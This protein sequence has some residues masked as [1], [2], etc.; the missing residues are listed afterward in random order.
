MSVKIEKTIIE[1]FENFDKEELKKFFLKECNER[2][3]LSNILESV[4]NA[5]IVANNEGTITY[6]NK[7][8]SRLLR[9]SAEELEGHHILDFDF[10]YTLKQQFRK[11]IENNER[12]SLEEFT[13]TSP[14]VS[15]INLSSFPL[16][17]NKK[18]EGNV[19]LSHDVTDKISRDMKEH[20]QE[21]IHS[22]SMLTAGVAHEIKNPLGALDL[23]MQL[24]ER[25]IKK[26]S[27]SGKPELEDLVGIVKD[28][29]NRLD[30]IVNDFL[31][32][33]RP[34][35]PNMALSS[36]NDVI[37]DVHKILS[38]DLLKQKIDFQTELE[39]EMNALPL[40]K[41]YIKQA[42]INI[43]QNSMFAVIG[44]E[45]GTILIRTQSENGKQILEIKDNGCGIA[46][47]NINKIFEPFFSTRDTGT[48]LGLTIT[49]KI[50][51]EHNAEIV[52]NSEE[53]LG[54]SFRIEFKAPGQNTKLLL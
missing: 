35:R 32:S 20:H 38:P 45:K 15:V 37:L 17:H 51:S 12:L 52:I 31:F 49:Y 41:D 33:V 28:E 30:R 2:N 39:N 4:D 54:T 42:I 14:R 22:L 47:E 53:G 43:V 26:S 11:V 18:I 23:H 7:A 36:L 1:K 16:L 48:G 40:D 21:S 6:I 19:F 34:I 27:F 24:I 13:V 10:D 50:L 46:N 29:I 5:L 25:F 44:K 8:G 3:N 9:Y